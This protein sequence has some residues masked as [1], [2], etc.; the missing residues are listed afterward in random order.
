MTAWNRRSFILSVAGCAISGTSAQAAETTE[1][2]S[3]GTVENVL[4]AFLA[5]F[6]NLD[7][8]KFREYFAEGV[9]MFHPSPPHIRRIDSPEAFENAW[10][11]VFARIKNHS[12]RNQPPY[13][14]LAPRDLRIQTLSQE[15]ALATFH[16]V[17]GNITSR[18]SL[19]FQRFAC[20]WK[21][22]HL[23]AS[24]IAGS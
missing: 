15:I 6:D 16:L 1:S 7:W 23:H 17:D 13:M 9:T 8:Q 5:A 18:R 24:N 20:N 14:N 4:D 3:M 2:D 22:I 19:L 12:G 11:E 21:I 10:L